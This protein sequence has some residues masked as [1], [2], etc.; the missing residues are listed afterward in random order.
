M[1][2]LIKTIGNR[3]IYKEVPDNEVPVLVES[4]TPILQPEVTLTQRI[5][6]LESAVADLMILT[7]NKED[8]QI[9]KS[10]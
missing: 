1:I 9:W 4:E 10:L 2:C 8:E 7:I 6:A 3:C 5:D